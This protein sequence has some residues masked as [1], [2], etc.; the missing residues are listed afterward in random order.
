MVALGLIFVL[1]SGPKP[2]EIAAMG[3]AALAEI[4][5]DFYDPSTGFY[6]QSATEKGKSGPSF[7]WG[8]GVLLSAL[9]AAAKY[10]PAKYALWLTSYADSMAAYWNASPPVAGFDASPNSIQ[11]DRYYDDNEWMV[12]DLANANQI[13]QNSQYL[14]EA[15]DSAKFVWSGFSNDL[16]GG[17]FWH[18][19]S[20]TSK[21]T[22]SNAPAADAF[23][24]LYTLTNNRNYLDR[25]V[26]AYDWAH[27]NL[28]DPQTSLYWDS[29]NVNGTI[30]KTFWSYNTAMMIESASRLFSI[31]QDEKYRLQALQ[32]ESAAI[33]HWFELDGQIAD[34]GKF[35]HLLIEALLVR[36]QLVPSGFDNNIVDVDVFKSLAWINR[37]VKDRNGRYGD[38]WDKVNSRPLQKWLLIDQAS[39]ARAF[40]V[41]ADYLKEKQAGVGN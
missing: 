8:S 5:R 17:I 7:C 35:A 19:Q 25:A 37:N 38:R 29:K 15:E 30:G 22:C 23:A 34:E 10:N 27:T 11:P 26:S 18:E 31:R 1:A 41:A 39:A 2:A 40:F 32:A 4:R 6:S 13:T 21:N 33:E 14:K 9:N 36:S 3:D 20:K 28:R 16:G 24:Q 12:R